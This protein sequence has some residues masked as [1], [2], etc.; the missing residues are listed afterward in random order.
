MALIN[1]LFP[2]QAH[3]FGQGQPGFYAAD[4][5]VVA[6]VIQNPLQPEPAH[7]SV[8]AVGHDG[9]VFL[10]NLDLVVVPVG[11]PAADLF[12]RALP[13]VHGFMVRVV[14]V[15][16]LALGAQGLLEIRPVH[17][18]VGFGVHGCP[19][20]SMCIPSQDTSMPWRVSSARSGE[21][22]FRIGLVLLMCIRILRWAGMVSSTSIMPPGPLWAR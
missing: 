13:A 4:I 12:G 19:D 21:S 20:R 10:G 5:A 1:H 9:G 17:G 22:S 11:H 14:D 6:I 15:V 7:T 2:A 3:R 8:R 16:V 18:G